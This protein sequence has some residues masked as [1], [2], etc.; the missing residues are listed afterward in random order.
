[1]GAVNN[2]NV[3]TIRREDFQAVQAVVQDEYKLA[4]AGSLWMDMLVTRDDYARIIAAG[5]KL[6]LRPDHCGRH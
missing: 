3:F 6:I 2:I 5:I 4:R 1:M